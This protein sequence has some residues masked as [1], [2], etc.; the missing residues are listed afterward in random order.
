MKDFQRCRSGEISPDDLAQA[1]KRAYEGC[2]SV[3]EFVFPTVSTASPPSQPTDTTQTPTSIASSTTTT[4]PP[5][6]VGYLEDFV[7]DSESDDDDDEDVED[8]PKHAIDG[9]YYHWNKNGDKMIIGVQNGKTV[10]TL[11][12]EDSEIDFLNDTAKHAHEQAVSGPPSSL[13]RRKRPQSR[14]PRHSPLCESE[15]DRRGF[16]IPRDNS[17]SIRVFITDTFMRATGASSKRDLMEWCYGAVGCEC[18]ATAWRNPHISQFYEL[19]KKK[20]HNHF[21][22]HEHRESA[23]ST[24]RTVLKSVGLT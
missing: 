4:G 19:V 21:H 13:G 7:L 8:W 23:Q 22:S 15:M 9:V 2:F 14:G 18:P 5:N 10:G 24:I 3:D 20:C 12:S 17:V 6:D 11:E 1:A 16:G